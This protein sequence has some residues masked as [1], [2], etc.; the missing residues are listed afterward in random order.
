VR[1]DVLAEPPRFHPSGRFA[2][3]AATPP[4]DLTVAP[5]LSVGDTG[6]FAFSAAAAYAA[7]AH[8]DQ[9]VGCCRGRSQMRRGWRAFA[10]SDGLFPSWMIE[11]R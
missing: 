7:D 5:S 3:C 9:V 8:L 2:F 11:A 1:W 10:T 6:Q 4:P